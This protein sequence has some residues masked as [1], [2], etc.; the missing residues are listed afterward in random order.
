MSNWRSSLPAGSWQDHHRGL[1]ALCDC[2]LMALVLLS[3]R[4]L[5]SNSPS[6]L[7]SGIC[8]CRSGNKL[9]T[10]TPA[11]E[12][13]HISPCQSPK[14]HLSSARTCP[15]QGASRYVPLSLPSGPRQGVW[16]SKLQPE[17]SR[18][19]IF[20]FTSSKPTAP[21]TPS[22]ELPLGLWFWGLR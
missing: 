11:G 14:P 3:S 8:P 9:C 17:E 12:S 4:Q 7:W 18:Q 2:L 15:K 6:P 16:G 20:F 21:V 19:M 13:P 1:L 5:Q 22:L 10:I